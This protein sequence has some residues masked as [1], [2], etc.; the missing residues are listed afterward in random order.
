MNTDP[1][2]DMLTRLR[3]AASAG[4]TTVS[5]PASKTK[6]A[7]ANILAQQ[8]LIERWEVEP[9]E[10][11][12]I[13][14]IDLRYDAELRSALQGIKRIS[15]PGRRVYAGARN[16]PRVMGGVGIVLVSTS[17]GLMTGSDAYRKRLGGEIMCYAW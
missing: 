6:L 15:K 11:Q 10:P 5:M 16:I 12:D 13:L 4:N 1:I 8:G 17:Q 7:I 14:R 9:L 3:N 2:A